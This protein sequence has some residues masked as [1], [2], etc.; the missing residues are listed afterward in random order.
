MVGIFLF[1]ITVFRPA[2]RPTNL[3]IQ[4]LPEDTSVCVKWS[5]RQGIHQPLP[6]CL[7][8]NGVL[9]LIPHTSSRCGDLSTGRIYAF[10]HGMLVTCGVFSTIPLNLSGCYMYQQV[11]Y[12]II[13]D[14]TFSEY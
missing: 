8:M 5:E 14:F 11:Q 6:R 2:L 7:G 10:I 9:L 1:S 3:P 12:S 13:L 4:W